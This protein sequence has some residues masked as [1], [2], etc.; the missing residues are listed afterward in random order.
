MYGTSTKEHSDKRVVI[1]IS[2]NWDIRWQVGWY[3]QWHEL[4]YSTN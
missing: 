3:M 2:S 4:R 1:G